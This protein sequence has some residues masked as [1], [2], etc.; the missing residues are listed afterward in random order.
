MS[1]NQLRLCSTSQDWWTIP[2]HERRLQ[3]G[4]FAASAAI[5]ICRLSM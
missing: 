2:S 3:M 1:G 5:D 4:D